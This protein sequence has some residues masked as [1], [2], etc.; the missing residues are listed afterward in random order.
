V[1]VARRFNLLSAQHL[2]VGAVAADFGPRQHDLKSEVSLDLPAELLQRVAEELLHLPAA[3]T[4][5]VR[6]LLLGA[7]LVVVLIGKR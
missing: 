6:V 7:C 1:I 5:D 3:K 2:A 4:D